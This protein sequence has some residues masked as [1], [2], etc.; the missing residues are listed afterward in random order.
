MS[1]ATALVLAD[2]AAVDRVRASLATTR[3]LIEPVH[4]PGGPEWKAVDGRAPYAW[5]AELPIAGV[6]RFF[7]PERE[8]LVRWRGEDHVE[9]TLPDPAPFA[10]F[11][12]RACDLAAL[13]Y[14]DRFFADDPYYGRRRAAALLVA[15]N[16]LAPCAGGFC[17]DVGAGPFAHGIFDLALTPLADGRVVAE[18]G[19][20]AG[21]EALQRAGVP[22]APLDAPGRDALVASE[23]A[24]VAAFPARPFVARAIARVNAEA[25]VSPIADHEWQALGPACFACT[26]CTNLCPT[27]SCFAVTDERRPDGGERVRSWDSCLLEGFQREA[28][29][30]HPAPRAG[31]RVR[32]FWTHKL[33][34]AFVTAC[35]RLG[36][37]GCGRCDVTCPGSIGA[38]R[39]MGRLGTP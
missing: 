39:V 36:C 14:Q 11:G 26:G 29:G 18:S 22:L 2:R 7:L 38:L 8:P 1:A 25:D 35:G 10:L 5:I 34:E 15:V 28:S 32:R 16:C 13:A 17:H 27:C 23:R 37:V 12:L 33:D 9:A 3:V 20:V 4:G 6:K 24:A 30:H 31:D 19:S 21:A